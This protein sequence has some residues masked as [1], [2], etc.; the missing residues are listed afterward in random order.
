MNEHDYQLA[1]GVYLFAAFG[2]LVVW[3]LMTGWMWRWL[4]EPLRVI[5]PVLLFTPTPVDPANNEYAPAIAITALDVLFKVGNNAWRAVSDLA[6]VLLAAFVVYL[7]FV[8][9]RWPIE[10][11]A[12]NRRQR[13][14]AENEPTMRQLM[15][16]QLMPDVDDSRADER[17]G[18]RGMRIEPRL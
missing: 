18:N 8:A 3:F 5:V 17:N 15:Q 9:V 12:R 13:A 7:I 10:R 16:P 2:L 4:R 6:L 1:W 11:A 14:E